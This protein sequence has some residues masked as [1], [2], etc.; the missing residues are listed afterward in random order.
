MSVPTTPLHPPGRRTRSERLGAAA[1]VVAMALAVAVY[2]NALDNPFIYDDHRLIVENPVLAGGADLRAILWRDVTRPGV[3]VTF[4]IDRALWGPGPFGFHLT[5][6]LLHAL[7][8]GL[9]GLLAWRASEDLRRRGLHSPPHVVAPVTAL[10]FA[11]HPLMSQAVGY[12]SGRADVLCGTFVLAALLAARHWLRDGGWIWAAGAL[13]CWAAALTAKEIAIVVPVLLVVYDLVVLGGDEAVRARRLWRTHVP[14]LGAMGMLVALR[15]LVFATLEHRDGV[16]VNWSLLLVELDVIRRY[17]SLLL[18]PEGQA[19]F[20]PVSPVGWDR[21]GVTAVAVV[22]LMSGLIWFRRRKAPLA[23][24]GLL[25]FLV[26]LTPSIVLVV[27]DRGEPMAEHRVYLASVGLFLTAGVA[28]GQATAVKPSGFMRLLGVLTL[29]A[30]VLSLGGRTVLRNQR[31]A[32][33]T[34]VWMEAL[35]Q[36]PDHWLPALLLGEELHRTGRHADAVIAFRRSVAA[37]PDN[38]VAHGNL[39]A[40]LLELGD[41]AAAE[42]AF[43]AQQRLEPRSAEASNGLATVALARGAVE[44]ARRGYQ[45]T[46]TFA[47]IDIVARRGLAMIAESTDRDPRAALRWCQEIAA[48]AP[49]TA[50]NAEC[51]ARNGAVVGAGGAVR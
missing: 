18:V 1:C 40:C 48:I 33:P 34:L 44:E 37:N 6:V 47:P 29:T 41:G 21:A 4:V 39:G 26:L 15:L 35:Q 19:I 11:V 5:N 13:C 7:N 20:H 8:V 50:G 25:W 42:R 43:A 30:M 45:Q 31:W 10:L 38:A 28:A 24:F 3:T 16:A 14:L 36:A 17:V 12:I 23:S 51:L 22:G 46:L 9:V 49:A 32:S 27:L 2:A